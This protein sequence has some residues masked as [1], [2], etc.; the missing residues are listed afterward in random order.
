MYDYHSR[1]HKPAIFR[2]C[3]RS[4]SIVISAA[5]RLNAASIVAKNKL[6]RMHDPQSRP[7]LFFTLAAVHLSK[8]KLALIFSNVL[9]ML[10]QP[11]T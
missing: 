5:A 9:T 4:W 8:P 7:W 2:P 11:C 1:S 10:S 3:A 6:E